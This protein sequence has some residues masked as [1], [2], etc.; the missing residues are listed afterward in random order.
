MLAGQTNHRT[1][2]TIAIITWMDHEIGGRSDRGRS[3]VS[4]PPWRPSASLFD[5]FRCPIVR[6]QVEC[7]FYGEGT[8]LGLDPP[9]L[10]RTKSKWISQTNDRC[11]SPSTV[12]RKVPNSRS[13]SFSSSILSTKVAVNRLLVTTKK[14]T[15]TNCYPPFHSSI[16]FDMLTFCLH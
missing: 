10:R 16:L 14:L 13:T 12:E 4:A 11:T 7:P 1:E 5:Q 2:R 8:P 15:L 6:P 3:G 9:K